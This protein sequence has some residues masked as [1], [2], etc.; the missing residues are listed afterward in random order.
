MLKEG[1]ACDRTSMT[2]QGYISW[3]KGAGQTVRTERDMERG[4][5]RKTDSATH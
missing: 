1:G 5:S 4:L 2:G 3:E